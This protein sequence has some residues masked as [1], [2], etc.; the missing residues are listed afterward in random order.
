[1]S[2]LLIEPELPLSLYFKAAQLRS[3]DPP[4]VPPFSGG[5]EVTNIPGKSRGYQPIKIWFK[6]TNQN[7]QKR[8]KISAKNK[9]ISTNQLTNSDF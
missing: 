6:S 8:A 2:L 9:Q 3:F 5:T 7:Q 1:L 4:M